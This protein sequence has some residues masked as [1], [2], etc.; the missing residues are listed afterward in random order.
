MKSNRLFAP[1]SVRACL[2]MVL[3][4]IFASA[5]NPSI[6]VL[7]RFTGSTDGRVPTGQLIADHDGN[8]YG[9]TERG[10]TADNGIVFE[11]SPPATK[12]GQWIEKVLYRFKGGSDGIA[13]TAGLVFDPAG[14]LYGTTSDGGKCH[15]SCGTVFRLARPL[16]PG[17]SWI[18]TVLHAFGGS[19]QPDGG[20]PTGS[21]VFD[22]AD[23]LYGTTYLGGKGNCHEPGMPWCGVVFR[24]SP[25]GSRGGSWTESVLYS[26]AG[27]PD[28]AF[29]FGFLTIDK[30]GNFFGTTQQGGTGA[31]TD[32]EGSTIGCGTVFTLHRK[33]GGSWTETPIYNFQTSDSG[34]SLDLLLDSAGALYGPGGYDIVKFVPPPEHGDPWTQEALHQ[35]QGGISGR[36]PSS[37]VVA[38]PSGNLYGATWANAIESTYG[39]V[40]ELSP[41]T[42]KDGKWSLITLHKFLGNFDSAQPFGLLLRSQA[43]FLY[44]TT[45]SLAG[46]SDEI[47]FKIIP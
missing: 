7:H 42:M 32:G 8:L 5:S 21:L 23:N 15:Y 17:G 45:R 44:G 22:T 39:T 24:L 20:Q 35:F 10:G 43:G 27:S 38:D 4:A 34:A 16:K 37:G 47:V 29:P 26:F 11:L 9:T 40:Y 41:P 30:Q 13:P 46:G 6:V 1:L 2:A 12:G 25:P 28:G 36:L 31:C 33:N 14:N 18:E 19:R 3:Y